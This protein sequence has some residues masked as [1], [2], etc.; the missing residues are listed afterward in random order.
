MPGTVVDTSPLNYLVCIDE[1]EILPRLYGALFIPAAVRAELSHPKAPTKVREWIQKPKTWLSIIA[2]K[3]LN[4]PLLK[5]LAS[6]EQEAIALALELPADLLIMDDRDA[7][8]SARKL[9]IAT[10]GTLA[11]LDKA[12]ENGWLDLA[13]AFGKLGQTSFRLPERLATEMLRQDAERK[14]R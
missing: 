11:V 7:V 1:V 4:N 14:R 10:V 6:G 13:T 3:I 2:P 8:V 5:Q 9:G 12:S